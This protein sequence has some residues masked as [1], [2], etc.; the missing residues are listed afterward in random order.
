MRLFSLLSSSS[1]SFP[2]TP[3]FPPFSLLLIPPLSLISS[4]FLLFPSP[5]SCFLLPLSTPSLPSS[6]FLLSYFLISLYST[7]LSPLFLSLLQSPP[8]SLFSP[9]LP[10]PG[11]VVQYCTKHSNGYFGESSL[12]LVSV[13]TNGEMNTP[14]VDV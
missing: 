8:S 1:S 14:L 5:L 7:H 2:L 6:L 13:R 12:P 10:F 9:L 11:R 4:V 3:L